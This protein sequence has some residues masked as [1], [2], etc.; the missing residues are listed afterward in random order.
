MSI[1]NIMTEYFSKG[2][3]LVEDQV[4][5]CFFINWKKFS[6]EWLLGS[7]KKLFNLVG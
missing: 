7:L 1:L 5:V 2:P 3:K 4:I 6:Y